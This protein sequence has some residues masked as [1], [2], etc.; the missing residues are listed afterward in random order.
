MKSKQLRP[1]AFFESR[2][3]KEKKGAQEDNRGKGKEDKKNEE[4]H[5]F[6]LGR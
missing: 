3:N 2:M 4:L 6:V 1:C 5:H